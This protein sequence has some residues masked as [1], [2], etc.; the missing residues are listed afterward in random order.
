MSISS[1]IVIAAAVH[2][3]VFVS[4]PYTGKFGLTFLYISALMWAGLALFVGRT[5]ESWSAG[6]RAG[7]ALAFFM[8]CA[9]CT[10]S[11]MPQ[12]DGV[13]PLRKF[14]IGKYPDRNTLYY[15]LLRVGI[16]AP[17]LLPPKK[18]EKPL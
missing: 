13:S 4:Y 15:G 5:L 14:S 17:G 16:S 3:G 12:K 8:F 11:L 7:L 2:L 9:L 6:T 18:E 10:L 1:L